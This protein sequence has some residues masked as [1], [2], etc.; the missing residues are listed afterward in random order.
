[1]TGY[2]LDIHSDPA[3][4]DS[5]PTTT[6]G[7]IDM[8]PA[9]VEV[10]RFESPFVSGSVEVV[11]SPADVEVY[12]FEVLPTGITP[13][14]RFDVLVE[15]DAPYVV[16]AVTS[17]DMAPVTSK[18]V[19][20][21][22]ATNSDTKLDSFVAIYGHSRT[23]PPPAATHW[24]FRQTS[25]IYPAYVRDLRLYDYQRLELKG[26]HG[27]DTSEYSQTN[28][29]EYYLFYANSEQ[30]LHNNAGHYYHINGDGHAV[31]WTFGTP[32]SIA[33]FTLNQWIDDA[34]NNDDA[35]NK[36]MEGCVLEY[37]QDDGQTWLSHLIGTGMD[38][39]AYYDSDPDPTEGLQMTTV[40]YYDATRMDDPN[41]LAVSDDDTIIVDL[42]E[43]YNVVGIL[44]RAGRTRYTLNLM[45]TP[46]QRLASHRIHRTSPNL[47]S[48]RR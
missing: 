9:D 40:Q 22:I 11:P 41:G 6:R 5:N 31:T 4:G 14:L 16:D 48:P 38:E 13:T 44:S 37:S 15:S 30:T 26:E 46:L 32:T 12:R 23:F 34:E 35:E 18:A 2:R 7:Y 24:R 17:G 3:R 33:R 25:K 47:S 27:P 28:G 19:Y 45:T 8:G 21:A 29:G 43:S 10:Y 20:E 39:Q 1:M 36:R 42:G